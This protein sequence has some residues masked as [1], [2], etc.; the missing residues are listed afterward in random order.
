MSDRVKVTH[1]FEP[2]TLADVDEAVALSRLASAP[3]VY[4]YVLG[5]TL[6][7]A[8]HFRSEHPSLSNARVS[9]AFSYSHSGV[10][11]HDFFTTP[12]FNTL[13]ELPTSDGATARKVARYF[14]I[15]RMKANYK[16]TPLQ[17]GD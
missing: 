3:P 6:A 15:S 2:K 14:R 7:D 10:I 16:G 9:S 1:V 12:G 8:E 5:A 11:A 17:E 13:C 4:V